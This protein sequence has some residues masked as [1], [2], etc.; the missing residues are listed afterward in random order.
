MIFDVSHTFASFEPL[1]RAML[2]NL[3]FAIGA[4][5]LGFWMALGWTVLRVGAG[6]ALFLPV[7]LFLTFVRGTPLLVQIFI[8]YFLLPR[9]GI[10]LSATTAALLALTLHTSA[11]MTE[12]MRGGLAAVPKGQTE[13]AHALGMRRSAIWLTV[14]L[15]QMTFR[16][17]PPLINEFV[18]MMKATPLVSAIAVTEVLRTA[19]QI[20][21]ANF[22]ALEVV[23]AAAVLFFIVNFTVSMLGRSIERRLQVRVT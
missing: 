8:L 6:A 16:I 13:A 9:F 23:L 19:Q 20:F 11:F 21:S 22:R 5:F 2:V 1:A 3:G 14:V 18:M 7:S 10:D 15:P 17:V 4:V 12:I